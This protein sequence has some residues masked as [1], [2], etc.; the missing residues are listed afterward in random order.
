M[1]DRLERLEELLDP[2]G[3]SSEFVVHGTLPPLLPG[4]D[5]D[6]AGSIGLPVSAEN[7]RRLIAVAD[8]APYG[9]GAE[10]IVDTDVRRV[11]QIEPSR[12]TLRNSAWDGQIADLVTEARQRFAIVGEVRHELYKLLIYEPGS[13]FAPHRDT[14]KTSGMF[15]TL[16]VCLPSAHEGGTLIVEHEGKSVQI[17]FGGTASEFHMGYAAFYA[18]CRHEITPLRTGYRVCLVYNLALSRAGEQPSAPRS[19][20]AVVAAADILRELFLDDSLDLNKLVIPLEHHYSEEGLHPAALK[21]ADRPRAEVLARAAQSLNYDC[22]L[23][24]VTHFESG[25]VDLGTWASSYDRY[26][27]SRGRSAFGAS[28]PELDASAEFDEVFDD[29]ITLDH[30]IDMAGR[31]RSFGALHIDVDDLPGGEDRTGWSVRQE[32]HEATGNEGATMERWY[33]RCAVVLW[34]RDRFFRILAAEGQSVALPELERMVTA[35][36]DEPSLMAC[37]VF[38]GA[39]LGRWT[40]R[41][42]YERQKSCAGHMLAVLKKI[43]TI[44]L[45]LQY[46]RDVLPI[47]FTGDEGPTIRCFCERFGW[48]ALHPAL[49]AFIEGQRPNPSRTAPTGLICL[50]EPLYD[51]PDIWSS[52]RRRVCESLA[53]DLAQVLDSWESRPTSSYFGGETS[54]RGFVAGVVRILSLGSDLAALDRFVDRTLRAEL[55]SGI[56]TVIAPD[57][58]A[59]ADGLAE[60]PAARSAY[61]RLHEHC[62]THL[63]AATA[64]PPEPPADWRRD[65]ELKCPCDDCKAIRRFLADPELSVARFPLAERRRRHI[66][67]EI[68][69]SRADCTHLTDRVGSPYSLVC[70]KTNASHDRRR[71][72][73]LEDSKL[74]QELE[75]LPGG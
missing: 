23:A 41:S 44:E 42:R 8:Q 36:T 67:S 19:S 59:I 66:H 74:L 14:E 26:S 29:S 1:E 32:I 35:A 68:E 33:R 2:L 37:Q 51:K 49:A 5:V 64:S 61:S 73:Y 20:S 15:A 16:V 65:A 63:R 31:K 38:A 60:T 55:D 71:K 48:D 50:L 56:R 72:Q 12:F 11:W 7:A 34:P 40:P 53:N 10:T 39:I 25:S 52:K 43:G 9:R 46:L 28:D 45:V 30:W 54:R 57:L 27:R 70:K 4:L 24:L 13:F 62:L 47:E 75:A 6:G 21:G 3:E 22:F 58:K 17:D 69:S 18:D